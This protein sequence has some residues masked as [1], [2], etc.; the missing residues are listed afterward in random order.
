MLKIL[1]AM[2][3]NDLKENLEK[4]KKFIIH[5]KDMQYKEAILEVL[6]IKS[7]FDI[8]IIYEKLDGEISI[9]ELIQEIKKLKN[10]IEIIFILEDKNKILEEE[11]KKESIKN[12]FYN[13]EIDLD[14]FIKEIENIKL[15]NEESLKKEIND[16]Q[17]III[18]K[19]KEIE[20]YKEYNNLKFNEEKYNSKIISIIGK[21]KEETNIFI[22]KLIKK[23]SN[24][25][26]I[27]INNEKSRKFWNHQKEQIE[28]VKLN[29][30]NIKT[31]LKNISKEKEIIIVDIDNNYYEN[32]FLKK[33]EKIIILGNGNIEEIKEMMTYINK[34][35]KKY[36]I[37]NRKINII[38]NKK[39]N[40]INIKILKNIF[41]NTKILGKVNL[42]NNEKIKINKK[43]LKRI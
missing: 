35:N 33:S 17:K 22:N 7:D 11:I 14:E 42:Q 27:I 16:L 34:L 28:T 20:K 5:K 43:I 30:K 38:F 37:E 23:L 10:K 19:N 39:Q 36:L 32:Y 2:G 9:I 3:D 8:I 25:K 15:S 13:N 1:T 26:V 29:K 31:I 21:N 18:N 12:I 41:K 40:K 6:K 4:T 24:K